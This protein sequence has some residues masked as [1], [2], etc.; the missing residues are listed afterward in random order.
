MGYRKVG[1]LE[2]IWYVIRWKFRQMFDRR[3]RNGA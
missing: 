2:Q 1:T 3:K